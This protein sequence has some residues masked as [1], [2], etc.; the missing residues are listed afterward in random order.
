M[1]GHKGAELDR[2]SRRA[3]SSNWRRRAVAG[4]KLASARVRLRAAASCVPPAAQLR[5]WQKYLWTHQAANLQ[6]DMLCNRV[7]CDLR[8]A[9]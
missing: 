4:M 6:C 7:H 5:S 2:C 3:C 1:L 9:L 8:A